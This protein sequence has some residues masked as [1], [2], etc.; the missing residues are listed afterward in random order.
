MI[1]TFLYWEF[2]LIKKYKKI[3]ET[4]ILNSDQYWIFV[5]ATTF[6]LYILIHYLHIV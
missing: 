1:L 3:S 6:D 2:I 4:V 5:L